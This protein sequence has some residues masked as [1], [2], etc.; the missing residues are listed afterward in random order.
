MYN[1]HMI[2]GLDEVFKRSHLRSVIAH[3]VE[4]ETR[5]KSARVRLPCRECGKL[6]PMNEIASRFKVYGQWRIRFKRCRECLQAAR[7]SYR[8]K[9][10]V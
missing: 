4:A 9:E 7:R 8:R 2:D 10:S 5:M 6:R 1:V 3:V